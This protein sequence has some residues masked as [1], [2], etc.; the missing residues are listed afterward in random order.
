MLRFHH[1]DD[2]KVVGRTT[3]K[4]ADRFHLVHSFISEKLSLAH[5]LSMFSLYP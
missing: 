1:L 2:N 4:P 5:K 3:A